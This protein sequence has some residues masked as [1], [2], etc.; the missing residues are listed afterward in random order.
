MRDLLPSRVSRALGNL[1][2]LRHRFR[3]VR[4]RP[5][6]SLEE[7]EAR[8]EMLLAEREATLDAVLVVDLHGKVLSRNQRFI[9][10]WRVPP[11]LRKETSS[12]SLQKHMI[13]LVQ[14]E[15]H[16]RDSIKYI[17]ANSEAV[18]PRDLIPLKDGRVLS[19]ESVPIRAT[20]GAILGRA[21][22]FT[23]VT[24]HSRSELVE[25]ALFRIADLAR[26]AVD[27]NELYAAIHEAVGT[28]M[29]ATNFYIALLDESSGILKFPYFVDEKDER[30]DDLTPDQGL[31][32][33]VFRTGK[34]LLAHPSRTN[35]FVE[36][37]VKQLGAPSVDW[38]GVPLKSGER[39]YGVL[40]I[41]SYRETVRY[42]EQ[43][44]GIL[45][46][47]SQQVSAAIEH[48]QK[49]EALRA[50]EKRYRQMFENNRAM[51][52]LIDPQTARYVD[53]NHAACE[54]YGYTRAEF[55]GMPISNLNTLGQE[56]IDAEIQRAVS[57]NRS[58][59]NFTHRLADGRIRDVEV[60][61]GPIEVH[62]RLLLYTIVHDVTERRQTERD[63][64][65]S[66]E[67][68]RNI[69][70]FAPVGIYQSKI[71]GRL[72]TVN[73]SLATILGY[74][75]VAELLTRNLRDDVYFDGMERDSLVG[76][77][78]PGLDWPATEV[79]WKKK[80]G[81]PVWVQLSV[82]A[83]HGT[84]S[85]PQYEG[86]VIDVSDRKRSEATLQSQSAAIRASLDGV[87]ILDSAG[88]FTYMNDAHARTYGYNVVDMLGR[89]WTMLYDDDERERF[90]SEIMPRFWRERSW[91]GAAMGLRSDGTTFP[92]EVSLTALD[93]GG[94]VCVVRDTTERTYAEEQ[95]KHLAYHDALTGLPNRLLFRDRLG[96]AI[97]QAQRGKL[98]L[99]VLFFDLDRFKVINDS[100]GHNSGDQLLQS[101][102]ARIHFAIRESDTVARQG[103]DE[104]IVLLPAISTT[105][106]AAR[107]A[108]KILHAI[109]E[110]FFFDGRPLYV[111]T[112]I[113]I[114]VYPDDGTDALTLI[115][116]A[117]T[118][119][120]QAKALGRD[121]YQLFNAAVNARALERLSL[122]RD[123]RIAVDENQFVVH[124]Q[125][126][127]DVRTDTISGM[128]ALLRWNHPLL[129]LVPPSD[130]IPLAESCGL[131]PAIGIVALRAACQDAVL[132]EQKA[133]GPL[134]LAVNLS[135]TQ[136]QHA[137]LLET[138]TEIVRET[139]IS[140]EQL[141]LEITES[142][143]MLNPEQSAR[144]LLE[145]KA[146]GIR[147]SLDDFGTGHSSLSYLRRFPIDTLKIDQSFIRDLDV[148]PEAA[149]IVEAIIAM[150]HSLKLKVIAEGVELP[151]QRHFLEEHDCD[152]MQGF[153]LARPLPAEQF[154]ALLRRN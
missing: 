133:L 58:I 80:D 98:R 110:P 102:A 33:Y 26:T 13:S 44:K 147:I 105:E 7:L 52:M 66:E 36:K 55:N 88:T 6:A 99:A 43:E 39:T 24:Q 25:S 145:L 27:L 135:V 23:E 152:Q 12:E 42:G 40:G 127:Y 115:K 15:D 53:A 46:F 103:G 92:Q 21:S 47:V 5:T 87:S 86:F 124:Y 29:D 134:S 149:A 146:L 109:H 91:R 126:I 94:L 122:E 130:F 76:R 56:K 37:G 48:K 113:G 45:L 96:V 153:L 136:L 77:Y 54:F 93:D 82:H 70:D 107:I 49:E 131:M 148:A 2:R 19:R 114:S 116:N 57:Q 142:G 62:G 35:Q 139:G 118:A 128:E 38:L 84:D 73:R 17:A 59:F 9:D 123:L 69:F 63:L 60:H 65:S 68:F 117:D 100:L 41:Q 75:S 4:E 97:S 151:E 132:W 32:G 18:R 81:E 125:P 90:S 150:A 22:Y 78:Q 120:Y 11:A 101:V 61:S 3:P 34:A 16:E 28:L 20:D 14:Y 50:S 72:V 79:L 1:S 104:F 95:I 30:P 67:K 106:D 144:T 138:V 85:E 154:E 143:A 10:Q 74:D 140:P 8:L 51:Q 112:S 119:M 121:N 31:T 129:G 111:T 141:E 64:Q 108:E 83:I 137:S 89:S 71:N